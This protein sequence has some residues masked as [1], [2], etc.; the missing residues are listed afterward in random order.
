MGR[1]H[2]VLVATTVALVAA[3]GG[4]AS[5]SESPTAG[6]ASVAEPP[7]APE[8]AAAATSWIDASGALPAG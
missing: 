5:P 8:P 2:G 6:T 4:G 7:H 1:R 3:C